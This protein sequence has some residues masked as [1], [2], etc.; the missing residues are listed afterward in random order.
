M[1][2]NSKRVQIGFTN[3]SAINIIELA[4]KQDSK[5]VKDLIE[6]AIIYLLTPSVAKE[7]EAYLLTIFDRSVVDAIKA[8]KDVKKLLEI[9]PVEKE[10]KEFKRIV[11]KNPSS[12]VDLDII[13][14][15]VDNR[16]TKDKDYPM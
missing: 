15:E 9:L 11:N 5:T 13:E 7:N 2:K 6:Y 8:G 4:K 14:K 16:E 10:D 3:S 1:V 12:V